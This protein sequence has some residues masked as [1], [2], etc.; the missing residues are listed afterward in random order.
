MLCRALQRREQHYCDRVEALD[1]HAVLVQSEKG[2][3]ERDQLLLDHLEA[4]QRMEVDTT[5]YIALNLLELLRLKQ[6]LIAHLV[7]LTNVKWVG[8]E[9]ADVRQQ[10]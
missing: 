5:S 6:A 1:V 9:R 3:Q 4:D 8:P 7:Q 2:G 10:D